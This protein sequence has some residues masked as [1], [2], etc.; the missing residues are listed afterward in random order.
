MVI[1]KS[2]GQPP[3]AAISPKLSHLR[4][5]PLYTHKSQELHAENVLMTSKTM[6]PVKIHLVKELN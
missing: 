1:W 6:I 4:D 5:C 3:L 2:L